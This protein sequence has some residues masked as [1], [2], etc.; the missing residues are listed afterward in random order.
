MPRTRSDLDLSGEWCKIISG[1]NFVLANDGND[2]KIVIHVHIFGTDNSLQHLAEADI[3]IVDGTFSVCPSI[4]YQVSTIRIMKY[5]EIYIF[6]DLCSS[7]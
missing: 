4:F 6:N 1:E 2:D 5:N 7:A 3:V